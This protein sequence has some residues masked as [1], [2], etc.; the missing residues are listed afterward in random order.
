MQFATSPN[1]ASHDEHVKCVVDGI[2]T[3]QALVAVPMI[4]SFKEMVPE[5]HFELALQDFV[6]FGNC[7]RSLVHAHQCQSQVKLLPHLFS[8]DQLSTMPIS[9]LKQTVSSLISDLDSNVK[10]SSLCAKRGRGFKLSTAFLRYYVG[11]RPISRDC[12]RK[13]SSAQS[14]QLMQMAKRA[15]ELRIGGKCDVDTMPVGT[16]FDPLYTGLWCYQYKRLEYLLQRMR[17]TG[18]RK[19]FA[20]EISVEEESGQFGLRIGFF[21]GNRPA[22]GRDYLLRTRP[23]E[24]TDRCVAR[25]AGR[26]EAF[27]IRAVLNSR[28]RPIRIH[29]TKESCAS[30]HQPRIAVPI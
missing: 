27:G 21:V 1:V 25:V 28:A 17:G 24:D 10:E 15:L 19:R 22:D 7:F 14:P 11:A 4:A 12:E 6:R 9:S 2:E 29:Q 26:I 5:S 3:E 13:Q 30:K 23:S 8:F 20:A 18:A 16:F